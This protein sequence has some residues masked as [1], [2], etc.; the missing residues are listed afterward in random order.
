MN[1]IVTILICLVSYLSMSQKNQ[2]RK[3]HFGISYSLIN[4]NE[5]F[6]NPFNGYANYQLKKWD[7]L[8]LNGGV[9]VFYFGSKESANFSNKLGFNPNIGISHY[10][11]D[12]KFNT[13][14]NLGYYFDA[15]EFKPTIIGSFTTPKREIK[16]NGFT[17][18]PGLKY[19]LQ[20]NIFVDANLT[21]LIAKEKDDIGSSN[22]SNN[23]LF[24]IG[25]G[26]AF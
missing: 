24:N 26:V 20:T 22:S 23:T 6:R 13:Y 7:Q 21:L 4:D 9:R 8:N 14:I 1:K 25:I 19:F 11:K 10:F 16:T 3:F 15:F 17:I 5:V 18:S 12:D 2:D